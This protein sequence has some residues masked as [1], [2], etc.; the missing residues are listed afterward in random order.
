VQEKPRLWSLQ[1]LPLL[2]RFFHNLLNLINTFVGY[3]GHTRD[4]NSCNENA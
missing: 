4:A 1:Q 2:G 3:T